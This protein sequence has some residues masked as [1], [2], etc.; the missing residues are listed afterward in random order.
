METKN[1]MPDVVDVSE[2]Y[3]FAIH[4]AKK[5]IEDVE[6]WHELEAD[7]FRHLADEVK[8]DRELFAKYLAIVEEHDRSALFCRLKIKK[9]FPV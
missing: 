6:L 9:G 3:A 7:Y 5:C 4:F 1:T 2:M 8:H